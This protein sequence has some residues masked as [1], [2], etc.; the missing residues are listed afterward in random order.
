MIIEPNKSVIMPKIYKNKTSIT[1]V[2]SGSMASR[3]RLTKYGLDNF[4]K[5]LKSETQSKSTLGSLRRR[6]E[7]M[8]ISDG[9]VQSAP[10][11]S[12]NLMLASSSK[13][14]K[15]SKNVNFRSVNAPNITEISEM[16]SPVG[17]ESSIPLN[18]DRSSGRR[19]L[20]K[21]K[22]VKTNSYYE[23]EADF[24]D[25]FIS[26]LMNLPRRKRSNPV[27]VLPLVQKSSLLQ[28]KRKSRDI[29][30][31]KASLANLHPTSMKGQFFQ[32][33]RGGC[34]SSVKNFLFDKI[35]SKNMLQMD[36]HEGKHVYLKSLKKL[37]L[38]SDLKNQIDRKKNKSRKQ[39]EKYLKKY[40]SQQKQI[41]TKAKSIIYN[42]S[43]CFQEGKLG[44]SLKEGKII[45][46]RCNKKMSKGNLFQNRLSQWQASKQQRNNR[47]I[48]LHSL[49]NE[50]DNWGLR[51]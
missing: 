19:R 9:H 7:S 28:K 32:D 42:K 22:M 2:Y 38:V 40:N 26:G 39:Y 30:D 24:K 34:N 15:R 18:F 21:S 4:V 47:N 29:M 41:T 17:Q 49:G 50:M 16:L 46:E 23:L 10:A 44:D 8:S 37:G 27:K 36:R 20:S 6:K 5:V 35:E 12:A 11:L 3:I 31:F 25:K 51:V 45:L 33:S 13:L 43:R 48:R 14:R 1:P